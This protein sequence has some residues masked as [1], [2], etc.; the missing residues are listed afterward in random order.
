MGHVLDLE[1]STEGVE[2]ESQIETLKSIGCDLIQGFVW[3]KPV[4]V[5]DAKG[6]ALS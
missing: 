5:E 6:I 3:G 2:E 1:V 4:P